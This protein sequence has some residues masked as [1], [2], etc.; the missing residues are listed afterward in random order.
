MYGVVKQEDLPLKLTNGEFAKGHT[1]ISAIR[2]GILALVSMGSL[3]STLY[4]FQHVAKVAVH[5][6]HQ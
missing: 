1:V 4:E 5:R 2:L 6:F 3:A